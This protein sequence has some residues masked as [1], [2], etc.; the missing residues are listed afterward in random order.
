MFFSLA[1][2]TDYLAWNRMREL[3]GMEWV[4]LEPKLELELEKKERHWLSKLV[5]HNRKSHETHKYSNKIG[6]PQRDS[7]AWPAISAAQAA[8]SLA[9]A[10][11]Q[12]VEWSAVGPAT[13]GRAAPFSFSLFCPFL[14]RRCIIRTRKVNSKWIRTKWPAQGDGWGD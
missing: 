11:P 7:F 4:E 13:L 14:F 1:L 3:N 6:S 9:V 10:R 5:L 12:M 8:H 2:C